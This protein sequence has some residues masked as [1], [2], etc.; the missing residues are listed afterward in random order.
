MLRNMYE[1]G[2]M[3]AKQHVNSTWIIRLSNVLFDGL[4]EEEDVDDSDLLRKLLKAGYWVY[5]GCIMCTATSK[6]PF[7]VQRALSEVDFAVE[8]YY[9][10][11]KAYT[12]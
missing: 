11:L 6:I 7:L 1:W 10:Y 8:T 5:K 12:R 2:L 4:M 3:G 9:H